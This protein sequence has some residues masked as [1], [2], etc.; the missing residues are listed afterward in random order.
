[1]AIDLYATVY[2]FD[3]TTIDLCLSVYPWAPF[4]AHKAAIKLY[5]LLELRGS[6]P[7]FTHIS[8]GRT[9]EVN[10]LDLLDIE[11]GA[12]YLLDRGYLDFNRLFVIYQANAFFVTRAKSNKKFK[13][14]Y[15]NPVDRAN[16]NIVCD[17]TD[18]LTIFYSSKDYPATLRRVVIKDETGKRI[19][20]LADNFALKPELIADLYRQRWQVEL[21]FK[22]IKQHP[23]IKTFYGTNENAVKTQIWV[24][25][26]TY[27]LISIAK[28]RLRLPKSIHEI[29]IILSL[30]MFETTPSNQLLTP[31]E[32]EKLSEFEPQQPSLLRKTLGHY[33]SFMVI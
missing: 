6:I 10:T 7:T 14:R 5:T 4:R 25:V 27:V 20:F 29:L 17:Q 30:T 23:R 3:A 31:P 12:Y 21:F 15:S 26:C 19:N 24:A 11:P 16:S 28:K 18:V 22:W 8:D 33:G 32:P 2:T 9:H 1:L 13:R